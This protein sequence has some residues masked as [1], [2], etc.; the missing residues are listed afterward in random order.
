M[1]KIWFLVF[2]FLFCT[3]AGYEQEKFVI[4]STLVV[5]ERSSEV[6]VAQVGVEEDGENRGKQIYEYQKS[7]GI[8]PGSPYCAA[9]QYYCFLIAVRS[10]NL[11]ETAIPIKRT[12]LASALFFDAKQRGKKTTYEPQKHDLII[13]KKNIGINGHVERIV[14]V[15]TKGWVK[16]IGFNVKQGSKQGVFYKRRHIYHPLQRMI[17]LGLVGFENE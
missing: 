9:G 5:I 14:G 4:P 7:V 17:V 15:E 1:K 12:G 16:T 8:P 3:S 13:W 2:V 11:P 6:L 10:L